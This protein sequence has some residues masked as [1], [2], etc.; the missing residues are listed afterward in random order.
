MSTPEERARAIINKKL[1]ESG[2]IVQFRNA[3]NVMVSPN[4]IGAKSKREVRL[5]GLLVVE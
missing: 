5:H 1:A 3:V 4:V 2:W